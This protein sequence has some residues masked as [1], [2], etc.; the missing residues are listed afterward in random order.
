MSQ[1]TLTPQTTL[2]FSGIESKFLIGMTF[3]FILRDVIYSSQQRDNQGVLQ[4]PI[5]KWRR[6]PVYQEILQYS[7]QDYFQK[8]CDS[9]LL[10]PRHGLARGRTAGKS[11]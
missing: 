1:N 8:F 2:P 11:G 5:R 3:R 10:M 6:D 9:L 7:Y 4:H